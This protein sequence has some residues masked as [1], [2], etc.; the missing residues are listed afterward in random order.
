ME[1]VWFKL[2]Q[3]DYPPPTEESM[4]TDKETGPI[5]LG[6]FISDLKHIDF[7]LNRHE[8]EEFPATMPVFAT[9]ALKFKWDDSSSSETG[10]ELGGGAPIAAAAGMTF[11]ANLKTIFKKE[12]SNHE[13]F[14]RLDKY[15]V[16]INKPYVAR[17]LASIE[18]LEKYT[19]KP[20]WSMFVITGIM[21][22]R[23]ATSMVASESHGKEIEAGPEA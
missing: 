20:W 12:I 8:L 7:V 2:K 9:T 17:C 6:H 19:D 21:V 4:G 23:G 15:I 5:C 10:G 16:Q 22:A 1:K 14:D 3:P 18:S 11:K 13:E